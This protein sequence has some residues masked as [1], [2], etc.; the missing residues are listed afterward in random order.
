MVSGES[1]NLSLIIDTGSDDVIIAPGVYEPS[2][3]SI[4]LRK[5]DPNDPELNHTAWTTLYQTKKNS[6]GVLAVAWNGFKDT[7]TF[8]GITVKDQKVAAS[9]KVDLDR[10]DVVSKLPPRKS[11]HPQLRSKR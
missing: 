3:E 7:M 10:H 4:S 11:I 2:S 5:A 9:V 1:K 6:C 8:Q